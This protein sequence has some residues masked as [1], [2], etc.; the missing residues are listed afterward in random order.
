M[1]NIR[2]ILG[3]MIIIPLLLSAGKSEDQAL[4]KSD[5]PREVLPQHKKVLVAAAADLRY[6]MDSLV[7]AFTRTHPGADIQVVYGSSGNFY[8]QIRNG[9]PFDLFFSADMDYPEKLKADGKVPGPVITY[10]VGSLVLWSR[11]IDPSIQGMQ[12]LLNSSVSKIA[13]ANPAHAPYG[14]RAME[15]LTFYQLYD[16]VKDKLVMGEN[17]S[18]AAQFAA[19][20]SA[21]I[22]M[23][24]L[25]LALSPAFR[26]AGGK[27]W[28]IPA[29][30]HARQDQ[31]FVLTSHAEE[32][33]DAKAF[34]DFVR[35]PVAIS[36]LD[37]FGFGQAI[38]SRT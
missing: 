4:Y 31:G 33:N 19:S 25:S 24:A 35:T 28:L 7:A 37:I 11:S 6:A 10:G 16:K 22:G 27:Y 32:N 15:S 2:L 36:I 17:I 26:Q 9:A 5:A 38:P 30:S 12:T 14:K 29:G 34:S 1:K 3:T 20:G 13:I 18:Q 23:I 8:E 21:E